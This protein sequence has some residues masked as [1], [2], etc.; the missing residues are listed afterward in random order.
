MQP[1]TE[2]TLKL[3]ASSVDLGPVNTTLEEFG[4]RGFILE[5]HH[6]VYVHTTPEKFRNVEIIPAIIRPFGFV[7]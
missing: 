6:M 2:R 4:N 7:F 1:H 3:E 5:E